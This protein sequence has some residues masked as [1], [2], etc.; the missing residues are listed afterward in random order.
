M[1]NF[2][3]RPPSTKYAYWRYSFE[4]DDHVSWHAFTGG[5]SAIIEEAYSKSNL[6]SKK[7]HELMVD[8]GDGPA[9]FQFDFG[10]NGHQYGYFCEVNKNKPVFHLNRVYKAFSLL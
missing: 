9:L 8:V 3:G 5:E 1:G 2:N 7:V 10:R 6:S 4:D